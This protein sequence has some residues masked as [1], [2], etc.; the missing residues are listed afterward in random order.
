M[1]LKNKTYICLLLATICIAFTTGITINITQHIHYEKSVEYS[2]FPKE[3]SIYNNATKNSNFYKYFQELDYIFYSTRIDNFDINITDGIKI[4]IIGCQDN[5][6]EYP[7]PSMKSNCLTTT[8]L[9]SG[10]SFDKKDMVLRNAF[11]IMYQSHLEAIKFMQNDYIEMNG[12]RFYLKGVL[13]DTNEVLRNRDKSKIQ[14]FVPYTT[15]KNIFTDT[16]QHAII[17]TC[18]YNF[19]NLF[20]DSNFNSYYKVQ[21]NALQSV[22]N[23]LINNVVYISGIFLV[24][25]ICII[26]LQIITIK[27]RYYEIGIRRA[28]GASRGAIVKQFTLQA[29]LYVLLGL[30]LGVILAYYTF[31]LYALYKSI[32]YH[33]NLFI[34]EIRTTLIMISTYSLISFISIVVPAWI[35]SKMNISTI[36][37]EER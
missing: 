22:E 16:T 20:E 25:C 18:K 17:K 24:A 10:A 9:I 3:Y 8:E 5:F 32:L 23:D 1:K 13:K 11:F 7:L 35:G 19:E 21:K 26:I 30:I 37:I 29:Y 15:M 31:S 6:L 4:E 33:T 36:L 12:V 14:I 28:I 27:S 34:Y 2:D